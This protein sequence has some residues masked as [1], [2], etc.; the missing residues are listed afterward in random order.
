MSKQKRWFDGLE[1][2]SVLCWVWY[3]NDFRGRQ[4]AEIVRYDKGTDK[5]MSNC[6]LVWWHNAEPISPEECYHNETETEK[7][8]EL[9]ELRHFRDSTVG[10]WA[11]D[12]PE[13]IPDLHKELFFHIG[14]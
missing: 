3:N 10:L 14:M 1:E 2:K 5:F 12:K 6:P 9:K 8:K 11:T 7:L 4:L 13:V